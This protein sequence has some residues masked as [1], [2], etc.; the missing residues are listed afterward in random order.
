MEEKL[1]LVFKAIGNPIRRKILDILKESAKTTGELVE[2]F[3]DVTRYAIMK[4]LN[5][6]EEGN[7]VVVRREGKYRKNYL[8]AVPIQEMHNRWVGKYMES[9]A[10][11][12]LKFT[13]NNRRNW[14]YMDDES[15]RT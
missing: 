4:H 6:L 12:L 11:S 10:K 2:I 1:S 3:P 8:N 9:S 14:R 5:I 15:K 13:I 7:L